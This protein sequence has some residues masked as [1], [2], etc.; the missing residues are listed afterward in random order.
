MWYLV[1]GKDND[2]KKELLVES[3]KRGVW[4][5]LEGLTFGG[6]IP[7]AVYS[8]LSG[9]KYKL[10]EET[11]PAMGHI[12][13]LW[14][15]AVNG[16]NIGAANHFVNFAAAVGVG[17]NPQ[18]LEDV[19]VAGMDYFG[20]DQKTLRDFEM[21][22]MR[23]ISVPQSQ[24]DMVYFDEVALTARQAANMTADELAE[25]YASYK[26]LH[27]EFA[28]VWF[29]NDETRKEREARHRKKA[30]ELIKEELDKHVSTDS[31]RSLI[32]ESDEITKT[33]GELA[34]LKKARKYSEYR[35]GMSRLR[36]EHDMQIHARVKR[37]K[38]DIDLLTKQFLAP[39]IS[40]EE[41]DSIVGKMIQK[42]ENLMN[43]INNRKK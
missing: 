7:D 31:V 35:E 34:K 20:N 36:Q 6:T 9:D 39:G 23:V 42:R 38:H 30:Q 41:S 16:D 28:T 13:D 25:R 4:G 2:K 33:E 22:A 1:F 3:A 12:K 24:V 29:Y 18:T 40:R 8:L 43:Y 27:N 32:A 14:N 11:S 17:I 37:Y 26:L 21:F 19:A 15:S 10:E 5:P